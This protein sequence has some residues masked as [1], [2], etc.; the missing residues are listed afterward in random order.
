MSILVDHAKQAYNDKQTQ[1]VIFSSTAIALYGYDQGM[2]SLI[3]TNYDYL[4]TMGI[5]QDSALVGVVVAV[6]YLVSAW[7][8]GG[9]SGI[10]IG[11]LHSIKTRSS[12]QKLTF[13]S[14]V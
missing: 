12:E 2:M 13:S 8:N 11:E 7:A 6:Y 4:R 9:F 1:V 5:G 10:R 14:S 3:N